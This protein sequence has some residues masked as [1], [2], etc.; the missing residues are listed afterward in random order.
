MKKKKYIPTII[1]IACISV[2]ISAY[3]AGPPVA[4]TNAPGEN[5]CYGSPACHSGT[6]NAGPGFA[7]VTV[8][9]GVPP[10][11][12]YVP[13]QT[14]TMMPYQVDTAMLKGGFQ[15]V[16]LLSDNNGAG[17]ATITMPMNTQVDLD[18]GKE[19]VGQTG[20]GAVKPI[21]ANMHDWM[22]DWQA[23]PAGSGTVI[24]YAAFIAADGD[25]TPSGDNIYTDT[26]VLYEDTTVGVVRQPHGVKDFTI[27]RIYPVPA[28]DFVNIEINTDR[29]LDLH[30][31]VLDIKGRVAVR[32]TSVHVNPSG[33]SF[34]LNLEDL[35]AGTY[36]VK[37]Q[38]GEKPALHRELVKH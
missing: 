8:M 3:V 12:L 24:F 36:F 34:K 11:N 31:T 28:Q 15:V 14:Y 35:S 1:F 5:T 16:A 37:V 22:Y 2:V 20:M 38:H 17:A 26:L 18:N 19:Y 6:P 4:S 32:E 9:G 21:M 7:E 27:E 23:P 10:G 30:V 29:S 33:N 25:S 13:G